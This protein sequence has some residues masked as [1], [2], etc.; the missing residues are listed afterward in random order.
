ME[1]R[2]FAARKCR[3]TGAGERLSYFLIRAIS[4]SAIVAGVSATAMPAAFKASILPAAVPLPPET[5][6]AGVTLGGGGGRVLPRDNR[7][8]GF[9]AFVFNQSRAFFST[10]PADFADQNYCV[11]AFILGEELDAVEMR[12]SAD[13]IA[14]DS[15]AGR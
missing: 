5:I 6:G 1:S 11:R 9:F 13:R 10:R 3:R 7:G 15:D 4:V 14:A 2:A 8:D 12:Q